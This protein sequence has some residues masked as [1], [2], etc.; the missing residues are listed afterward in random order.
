MKQTSI[1][2]NV[3]LAAIYIVVFASSVYFMFEISSDGF[4][5]IP[6]MMLTL[7]WSG[8][9]ILTLEAVV[10]ISFKSTVIVTM[11]L[12]LGACINTI[13]LLYGL[14]WIKMLMKKHTKN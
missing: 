14:S 9:M 2:W 1:R 4:G 13:F 11:I 3:V 12:A 8:L 6:A 7:P 10:P 5:S